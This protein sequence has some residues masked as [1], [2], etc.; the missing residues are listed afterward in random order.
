MDYSGIINLVLVTA[1]FSTLLAPNLKKIG[2]IKDLVADIDFPV[3]SRSDND[4]IDPEIA[5]KSIELTKK[6]TQYEDKYNETK[7]FLLYFYII[8]TL[9]SAVQIAIMIIQNSL[10]TISGIIFF[11]AVIVVAIVATTI[12]YHMTKPSQVRSIQWLSA[13]GIAVVHTSTLFNPKFSLNS[14]SKIS[15]AT[16]IALD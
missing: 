11:G 6:L 2:E 3:I 12:R 15:Y 13:K 8:I 5:K 14:G 7:H 10:F 4:K 16:A 9:I 1:F